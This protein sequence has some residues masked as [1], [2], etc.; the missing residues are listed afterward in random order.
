M[1]PARILPCLLENKWR[2]PKRVD[3]FDKHMHILLADD[4]PKV[5]SALRLLLEQQ[6][7]ATAI[8]E[9]DDA[10]ALLARA[11]AQLP[12][13]VLLDWELPGFKPEEC[14]GSLRTLCPAPIIVAMS[15]NLEAARPALNA[16]ADA[17]ISKGDPPRTLLAVLE[18]LLFDEQ[19]SLS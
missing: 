5:R 3:R 18:S 19:I 15:V 1:Q 10:G 7:W 8:F 4:Q 12:G 11:S 2:C 13:L 16:G 9:A 6:P 14:L 17:F